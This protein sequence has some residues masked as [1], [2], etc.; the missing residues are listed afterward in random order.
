MTDALGD[1]AS[2]A[3]PPLR[4]IAR[5]WTRLGVIGFGGPPAH[6]AL[7]RRLSVE[8]NQWL[9]LEEFEHAVTATSLLPGPAST[10][11]VIYA[12]WRLRGARGAVLGGV[13]FILP[14]LCLIVVLS[15]LF[16]ARHPTNGVFGAALGAG[17]VVP[18][19]AARTAWQL[20]APSWRQRRDVADRSRAVVYGVLG[21]GVTLATPSLVVLALVTCGAVEVLA[22]R[23]GRHVV[24][25]GLTTTHAIALGA[26]GALGS[27]GALSWVAFKVGALSYGGG[28]VI[29]PLMQ[30]DVVSTYHWMTGPQFLNAVA[31]GQITPGPVVLTVAAV[32]YAVHGLGGAALGAAVAFAPSFLLIIL[33]A[34]SFDRLRTNASVAAFLAGAGPSVIGAI[35]ASSV[36]LALLLS[37]PWQWGVLA[38]AGLWLFLRRRGATSVLILSALVGAIITLASS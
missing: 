9:S 27:L 13:C 24:V 25:A 4:V 3:T 35:G 38:T 2:V 21:A 29:I 14:G 31:L 22:R 10:Q 23:G 33:G 11:L 30:H 5:E 18:A 20:G 26:L 15:A 8:K 34:R 37:R 28:F 16:F 12:A 6:I 32:G 17:A 1:G 36:S 7:L 19:I